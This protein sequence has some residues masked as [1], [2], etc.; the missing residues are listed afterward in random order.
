MKSYMILYILWNFV[1]V[2]RI[3]WIRCDHLQFDTHNRYLMYIGI[4]DGKIIWY[5][6][7]QGWQ[8]FGHPPS[9]W[10]SLDILQGS[11]ESVQIRKQSWNCYPWAKRRDQL[12]YHVFHQWSNL[13]PR[14][15]HH[16]QRKN[17]TSNL[18]A[19][20]W[21]EYQVIS[22]SKSLKCL[23]P[24]GCPDQRLNYCSHMT[25]TRLFWDKFNLFLYFLL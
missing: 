13:C 19:S 5:F 17:L 18:C 22:F 10:W 12:G 15:S 3:W 4:H 6:G 11:Q 14:V 23:M 16:S 1:R 21:Q 9:V 24:S 8:D 20:S 2:C 25:K 7:Y